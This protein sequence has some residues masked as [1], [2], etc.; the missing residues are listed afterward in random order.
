MPD[1]NEHRIQTYELLGQTAVRMFAD[2]GFDAVTVDDVAAGAGVSRRTVFRYFPSKDDL[3]L[4][5]PQSWTDVFDETVTDYAD[6]PVLERACLGVLAIGE[7][8]DADPA[9]VR[10]ALTVAAGYP[11]LSAGVAAANQQL[12]ARIA[13]E[14]AP[15]SGRARDRFRGRIVAGALVGVLDTALAEWLRLPNRRI[16]PIV[17]KGLEVIDPLLVA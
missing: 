16:R 6:E 14:I 8:I 1:R 2:S 17:Q 5:H 9:P 4:V 3:V 10:D 13:D 12:A 11:S 7:Q 15:A